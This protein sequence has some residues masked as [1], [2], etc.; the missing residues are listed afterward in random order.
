MKETILDG[1][2]TSSKKSIVARAETIIVSRSP[3][4]PSEVIS[5]RTDHIQC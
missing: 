5:S 1:L 4:V 2:S 3:G